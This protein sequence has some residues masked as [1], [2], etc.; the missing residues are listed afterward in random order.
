MPRR[1]LLPEVLRDKRRMLPRRGQNFLRRRFA[2]PEAKLAG[3]LVKFLALAIGTVVD[4][5]EIDIVVENF[6][7]AG[8]GPSGAALSLIHILPM[9]REE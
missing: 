4:A 7:H 3:R 2:R 9:N 1:G 8:G 5:A 6:C